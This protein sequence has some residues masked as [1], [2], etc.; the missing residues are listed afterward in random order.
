M[1]RLMPML[2][3]LSCTEPIGYGLGYPYAYGYAP[4]T[5]AHHP[6]VYGARYYANSGGAVHIVK[7]DADAEPT[8]EPTADADADADADAEAALLYGAYG[9][10]YAAP[11]AY[12]YG[13]YHHP[14][15]YARYFHPYAYAPYGYAH[16]YLGKRSAD[17]DAD[18][19]AY[20][21]YYSVDRRDFILIVESKAKTQ[22]Q[23]PSLHWQICS[24]PIALIYYGVGIVESK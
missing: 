3:R 21:G 11:Y 4:Y 1:P 15:A 9:Y 20:Y 12:S 13:A 19:D 16:H 6:Y 24:V 2:T 8:A 17:A 22:W 5:Y 18:A 7:R 23:L 14:Y 10:G